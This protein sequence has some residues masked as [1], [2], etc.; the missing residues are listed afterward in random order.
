MEKCRL[1]LQRI[2]G[3]RFLL[4]SRTRQVIYTGPCSKIMMNSQPTTSK[5]TEV[6][7]RL[8]ILLTTLF[9][10]QLILC[11]V[12]TL[13]SLRKQNILYAGF[14]YLSWSGS[15]PT[16]RNFVRNFIMFFIDYS[17]IIPISLIVTMEIVKL[18]QS[19]F[20]DFDK[21]MYSK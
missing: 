10:C 4:I 8:N 3:Q 14:K 2:S 19:Y 9:F 1:N 5:T 21:L 7:K 11:I 12:M 15:S 20:I 18:A 16:P 6:E 17:S 13:L